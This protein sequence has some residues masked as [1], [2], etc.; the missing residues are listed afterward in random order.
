[1][2]WSAGIL[3]SLGR[4]SLRDDSCASSGMSKV[5]LTS[6]D[7][8]GTEAVDEAGGEA[9]GEAGSELAAG[10]EAAGEAG[11]EVAAGGEAAAGGG[12]RWA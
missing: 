3:V 6:M 7:S 8:S 9:A 1:M 10:G 5:M 4:L 12:I 11:S 2:G